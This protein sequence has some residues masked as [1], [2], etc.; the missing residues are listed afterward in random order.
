MLALALVTG[1]TVVDLILNDLPESDLLFIVQPSHRQACNLLWLHVPTRIGRDQLTFL[2]VFEDRAQHGLVS[3]LRSRLTLGLLHPV[4][5][6]SRPHLGGHAVTQRVLDVSQP[7]RRVLLIL[8]C[9]WGTLN[10]F[11]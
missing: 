1:A 7:L 11:Q 8:I 10:A 3:V 6:L 9:V 4:L 2:P 5:A